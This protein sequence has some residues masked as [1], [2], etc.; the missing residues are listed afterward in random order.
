[1]TEAEGQ[2]AEGQ[3][4]DNTM[5]VS[6]IPSRPLT[7]TVLS[8]LPG[9]GKSTRARKLASW[10]YAT[11]VARDDLRRMIEVFDESELT[12]RLVQLSASFLRNGISII[13]DSQNLHPADYAR[14]AELARL[15]GARLDWIHLDVP[16]ELCI[17]RDAQ[18]PISNGE[19]SIRT[20]AEA[21][22]VQLRRLAKH[23]GAP[24]W[25][26]T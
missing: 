18:R 23:P 5:P 25:L 20:A 14:W 21:N 17:K 6:Y 24:S 7:L 11:V 15:S 12:L 19:S 3:S 9:S 8:G 4:I 22:A 2:R 1:M 10:N 26:M 16:L 13:V